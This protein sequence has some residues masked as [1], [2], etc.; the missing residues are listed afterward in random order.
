MYTCIKPKFLPS[1]MEES[2]QNLEELL[3]LCSQTEGK[4][5]PND[6][7]IRLLS[8]NINEHR[9]IGTESER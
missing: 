1:S 9:H 7:L 6:Y 2:V 3:V 8:L 4:L 5:K